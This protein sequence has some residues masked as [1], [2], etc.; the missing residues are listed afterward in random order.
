MYNGSSTPTLYTPTY[1]STILNESMKV[2]RYG[3]GAGNYSVNTCSVYGLGASLSATGLIS[4]LYN[5]ITDYMDN[6]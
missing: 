1:T 5:A 2:L 6:I 3:S 4:D